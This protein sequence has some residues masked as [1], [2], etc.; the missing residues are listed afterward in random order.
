MTELVLC[1]CYF[2]D[3][4]YSASPAASVCSHLLHAP[5]PAAQMVA[6]LCYQSINKH[7]IDSATERHTHA[8]RNAVNVH[9][10]ACFTGQ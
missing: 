10:C 5:P 4:D 6:G 3:G 1:M 2:S 9:N 8:Q 7:A